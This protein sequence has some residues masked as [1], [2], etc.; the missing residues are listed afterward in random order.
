MCYLLN[1]L[2][3][4]ID[5]ACDKN[6]LNFLSNTSDFIILVFRLLFKKENQNFTPFRNE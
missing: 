4:T 5:L 2:Q 3:I 1:V 6:Q